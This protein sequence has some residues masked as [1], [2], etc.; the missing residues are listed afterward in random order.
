[1]HHHASQVGV[2][3][4]QGLKKIQN[5]STRLRELPP[6]PLGLFR[7]TIPSGKSLSRTQIDVV[8]VSG[9]TMGGVLVNNVGVNRLTFLPFDEPS[10]NFGGDSKGKRKN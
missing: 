8:K 9:V 2:K 3:T 4:A 6:E 10:L 5:N 7:E 1:M